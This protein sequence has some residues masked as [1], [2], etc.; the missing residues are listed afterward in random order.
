VI[1]QSGQHVVL[2]STADWDWPY[3]TN[4]QH[5]AVRLAA[6]G[7]QVLYVESVGLRRPHLNRGDV[8][9]IIGRARHAL[10][11]TR[12]AQPNVWVLSP[13][14]I[15]AAHRFALA[16]RFNAWQLRRRITGWLRERRAERPIVWTYHPYMLEVA[17]ALDPCAVVYHCVDDNGAL[18]GVDRNSYEAA[19]RALIARADHIFATSLALRDRCAAIAPERTHYFANVTDVDHFAAARRDGSIPD[20]LAVI[21]RPRLGYIGVLSD[22]KLDLSLIERVVLKRPGWH[23]VFIGD[24][25]EGQSN[26]IIAR[27]RTQPNVHMLGWR[28]YASLP[29]Y[30]RGI[31]IALLPQQINDYT[32][33]MFPMKF[34]EY[35]AAGRVVVAT[36]LPALAEFRHLC[37]T[38][39]N[40]EEMI[41]E[42]E[43]ILAEPKNP[44]LSVYDPVLRTHSWETRLDAMLAI[45]KSEGPTAPHRHGR[46]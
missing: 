13:L 12:E 3:W 44:R 10:A 21:A 26:S 45:L 19:E 31:D 34:F 1:P 27:L 14:T 6:R 24:E 40:A 29:S 11:P 36:K 17:K 20:E 4:K 15:P 41:K 39:T 2:F 35:L 25:R 38:V 18:P 46:N 37:R 7:C 16:S 5:M 9:R 30:L 43:A 22:F 42:I 32:R 23:W 33:A 28:S 8:G